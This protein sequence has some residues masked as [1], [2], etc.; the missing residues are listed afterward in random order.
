MTFKEIQELIKLIAKSNLTEFK[1]KDGEFELSV[2]TEKYTRVKTQT[3]HQAPAS[4]VPVTPNPVQV[5]PNYLSATPS[6]APAHEAE[7]TPDTPA[8]K[9]EEE[10]TE[11]LITIKSPMV[12][13]FYRSPTP[14][15]PPF[16]KVGDVIEVGQVI[17]IVEAMK[18]FNDI[19]AEVG[20]KIV[21]VL[22]DDAA[23]VEYDQ[24]LFLV[25]P[26]G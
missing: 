11:G 9:E 5:A 16:V 8:N 20:G 25:D 12:G 23:P 14:E 13:T 18:L 6:S 21:K 26:K 1:M 22:I 2:R 17:C 15:K 4:L 3:V 19:E 10:R 24:P 7:S